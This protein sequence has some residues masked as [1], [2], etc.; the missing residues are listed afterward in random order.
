MDFEKTSCSHDYLNK[1]DFISKLFYNK[2]TNVNSLG[3]GKIA[4]PCFKQNSG[5][6][7][8]L[9]FEKKYLTQSYISGIRKT[10]ITWINWISK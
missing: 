5:R 1:N 2:A 4:N 8:L 7:R 3:M 9:N 10:T 6:L